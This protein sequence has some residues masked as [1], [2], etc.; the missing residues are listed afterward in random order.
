FTILL[1]IAIT[2]NASD[3]RH[4]PTVIDILIGNEFKGKNIIFIKSSDLKI[5]GKYTP[6]SSLVTQMHVQS[7]DL[8]TDKYDSHYPDVWIWAY[9]FNAGFNKKSMI[10]YVSKVPYQFISDRQ[11]SLSFPKMFD[12]ISAKNDLFHQ[13]QKPIG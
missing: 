4:K 7:D 12:R 9:V 8:I 3:V 2:A 10:A 11:L 6:G 1:L 5:I 13:N